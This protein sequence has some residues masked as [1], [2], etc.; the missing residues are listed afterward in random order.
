MTEPNQPLASPSD[1]RQMWADA[2]CRASEQSAML[3]KFER[4]ADEY[5]WKV[6]D[7][8]VPIEARKVY[9][10]VMRDLYAALTAN[11][12]LN[13][14]PG[15]TPTS[16]LRVAASDLAGL[17]RYHAMHSEVS[18]EDRKRIADLCDKVERP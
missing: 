9:A 17:A 4:L 8:D 2:E 18:P 1:F 3:G 10:L 6:N 16:E 11:P 12:Y 13:V 14:P 7:P 5:S 15:M